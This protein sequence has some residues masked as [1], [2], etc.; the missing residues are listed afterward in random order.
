[1]LKPA[2][3]SEDTPGTIRCDDTVAVEKGGRAKAGKKSLRI[4]RNSFL[5]L[6]TSKPLAPAPRSNRRKH[7]GSR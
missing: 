6:S 4:S 1:M 2:A 3:L 5:E 7:Y